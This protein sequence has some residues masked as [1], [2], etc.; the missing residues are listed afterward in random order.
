VVSTCVPTN[1]QKIN[2]EKRNSTK[3][4]TH[5]HTQREE[6]ERIA[7]KKKG[8]RALDYSSI[9]RAFCLACS[10]PWVTCTEPPT[11]K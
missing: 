7:L 8:T 3:Q 9:I 4:N 1:I 2:V 11:E 5:T 6:G 10:R